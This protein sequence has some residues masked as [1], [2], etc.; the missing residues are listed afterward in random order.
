MLLFFWL[1]VASPAWADPISLA[2]G[3]AVSGAFGLTGVAATAVTYAVATVISVTV[4]AA[5]SLGASTLAGALSKKQKGNNYSGVDGRQRLIRENYA[6]TI[7]YV[8]VPYGLAKMGALRC[9]AEVNPI[10]DLI[11]VL[12]FAEGPIEGFDKIYID[13]ELSTSPQFNGQVRFYP[14]LG[15]PGQGFPASFIAEAPKLTSAHTFTGFAA[16]G[17]VFAPNA[18]IFS[19]IPV[20]TAEIKGRKVYDP[21]SGNTT[22]SDNPALCIRDYLTNA[23]YGAQVLPDEIDD[24]SFVETANYCDELVAKSG[25]GSEKRYTCNGFVVTGDPINNNLDDLLTSCNA[26]FYFNQGKY[27]LKSIKP[28][29]VSFF[30]NENDITGGVSIGYG[31]K[32]NKRNEV[33]AQFINPE[34]NWQP[35]V[36]NYTNERFLAQDK[37]EALYDELDLPF[38]TSRDTAR[39]IAQLAVN[40]SRLAKTITFETTSKALAWAVGDVVSIDYPLMNWEGRQFRVMSLSIN[41]DNSVQASL[42]EYDQDVY[43]L[44]DLKPEALG[45]LTSFDRPSVVQAPGGL[46]ITEA[47]EVINNAIVPVVTFSWLP[48]Q[49]P[50]VKDYEAQYKKLNETDWVTAGVSVAL[51]RKL[52]A[53]DKGLYEFRVKAN[54]RFGYSSPWATLRAEV[55]SLAAPPADIDGLSLSENGGV[56]I[57]SWNLPTDLDVLNGGRIEIRFT[58]DVGGAV[59]GNTVPVQRVSG[60]STSVAVPLQQGAYLI[61]AE[62]ASG[63]QSINAAVVASSGLYLSDFASSTTLTLDPSFPGSYANMEVVSGALR[64]TEDGALFDDGAGLFDDGAGLFDGPPGAG[65]YSTTG[66]YESSGAGGYLDLGTVAPTTVV[67]SLL[68]AQTGGLLFD[69]GAG[70]FD[71]GMGLFDGEPLTGIDIYIYISTTDDNPAGSPAWSPWQRFFAG[72]FS[73]R[74]FKAKL[75][76]KS[77]NSAINVD[78]SRFRLVAYR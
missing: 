37:G 42:E 49:S 32:E 11:M 33:R 17:C 52:F 35:D 71:S 76:L 64:L 18:D 66:S 15:Q 43:T 48:S 4:G 50:L 31:G 78:I 26:V 39:R 61:K 8:P 20:I 9:Y 45:Q 77:S 60:N 70:L 36:A 34:T 25:G 40:Q 22:W 44:E 54:N 53:L 63:S 30:I 55:S 56:G 58:E 23:T 68:A 19:S 67:F 29:P 12:V 6:G 46:E 24:A 1:I 3:A 65:T 72:A 57:L 7:E 69:D 28:E 59:W 62:D 47:L 75:E 5:L 2:I 10:G 51:N 21:R 38:T 16:L 13:G 27:S 41:P 73:C 14:L 74:A